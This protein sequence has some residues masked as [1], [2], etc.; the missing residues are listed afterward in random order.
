MADNNKSKKIQIVK[1]KGKLNI[2]S[3]QNHLDVEKPKK[4]I[5][6]S[7]KTTLEKSIEINADD[8]T[9]NDN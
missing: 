8:I 1:G 6:T 7:K 9:R 3:V 2:S 4:K 5:N